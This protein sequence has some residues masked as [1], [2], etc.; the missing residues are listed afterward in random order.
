[1]NM[2]YYQNNLYYKEIGK[3]IPIIFLHGFGVDHRIWSE[4]IETIGDALTGFRRIYVDL[5][6]MG[7]SNVGMISRNADEMVHRLTGFIKAMVA[8]EPFILCGNSYGGY[9][10]LGL[11]EYFEHQILKLFLLCPVVIAQ[12]SNRILPE[13]VVQI[14]E[15]INAENPESEAGFRA[16]AT[17]VTD[18]TYALFQN[19]V[20]T[21]VTQEQEKYLENFQKTGY[22][23]ANEKEI[24]AKTFNIQTVFCLGKQDNV[25]GYKQQQLFAKQFTP[26]EVII[27][28]IAG[29][30]LMID[31]H[32]Q[33]QTIFK[34][35]LAN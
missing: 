14:D 33:F 34:D 23:L 13:K 31:E 27:S 12:S 16:F 1:M 6:G 2:A 7:K 32:E 15:K 9:L 25:V 18:K 29:H 24:L 5:E 20:F 30:N 28:D 35:F 3:G 8:D 17:V 26:V 21:A 10:S 19:S 11:L 22:T 4:N